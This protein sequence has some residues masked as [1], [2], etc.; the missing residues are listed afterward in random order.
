[1]LSFPQAD[2]ADALLME[3]HEICVAEWI[4]FSQGG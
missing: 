3:P 4:V 2:S 1:M